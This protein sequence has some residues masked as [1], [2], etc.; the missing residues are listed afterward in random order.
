MRP[1]PVAVAWSAFVACHTPTQCERTG[2][3]VTITGAGEAIE[4]VPPLVVNE[5]FQ[6]PVADPTAI[7]STFGPRYKTSASR[8]DFHLGI[9]YFGE[10]GTPLF[11]IGPGTVYG[12]YPD[13][14]E[15]YP[16][17]GNVLVIEHPITETEFQAQTVHR[18]FA[19]YLHCES[20]LVGAGEEVAAGQP[21]ATMG[22]T[23]DT[24]FVH[25]H[26]ETRV[27]TPCSLV[28]Q[29]EHS[30]T[31]DTGFDPH[32][33]PYLFVGGANADTVRVESLEQPGFAVRFIE[34]RGDLDLDMIETDFGMLG[35]D[36][37]LGI[38]V[39]NLDDFDYGYLRIVPQPFLSTSEERV[40]DLVF[41]ERPS[42][43]E[44]R[45]IYGR[46]LRF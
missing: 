40:L 15:T 2:V 4:S 38:D 44:L 5:S 26:F 37:R 46:G 25:L 17:G 13:G 30:G 20:F 22:H 34:T 29:R 32:V 27:E 43:L 1:G 33:H 9:D 21:V 10:Q 7:S 14:S 8:D 35:F 16:L 36:E 6:P 42:F 39:D 41:D 24:E 3:C 28:Y 18:V 45:D 19:V 31:C 23:G 12:T 11:A